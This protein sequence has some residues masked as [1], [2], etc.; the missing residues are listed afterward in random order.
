MLNN[1]V[2]NNLVLVK[3]TNINFE[4]GFC[5]ITGQSGSGKSVI[6][7]AI[8]LVLGGRF[9]K[10]F[11]REG[12]NQGFI[13]AEFD[14]SKNA[15][16]KDLL[17]QKA[18][19]NSENPDIL[20][21]RRA[22]FDNNTTKAFI[23]DIAVT[24]TLLDEIGSQIAQIQSQHQQRSLLEV[25]NQKII[26]DQYVDD[27]ELLK[28]VAEK[29]ENWQ[30]LTN[31]LVQIKEKEEQIL[32]EKNYLEYVIKELKDANI[33][34]NEEEELLEKKNLLKNK[35][36]IIKLIGEAKFDIATTDS[37]M[38]N[39][40]NL[41]INNKELFTQVEN[42]DQAI[43]LSDEITLK[44][45]QISDI[46]ADEFNNVDNVDFDLNEIDDRL[47]LIRNLSRKFNIQP[48]QFAEIL[49]SWEE[50]LAQID[51]DFKNADQLV[52]QIEKIFNEY[53][54]E[55]EKLSQIRQEMA[56]K[57]RAKCNEELEFLAM[58]DTEF[59]IDIDRLE[60]KNYS[61]SGIDKVL[62]LA[63]INKAKTPSEINKIA[64]GGELSRFM[65]ALKN[66]VNEK[67]S[68]SVI[69]FDEIDAGVSGIIA[70]KIGQRLRHLA[71]NNQIIAITHNIQVAAR[72]N[73]HI[74]VEKHE[75]DGQI[76]SNATILQKE[77]RKK[78]LE[79]MIVIE[80]QD[81]DLFCLSFKS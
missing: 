36:S 29:F 13:L 64:S 41:L 25:K 1:L 80:D 77:Q 12:E 30:N 42:I 24:V 51:D 31:Q 62:F 15:K 28:N 47:F 26:L 66:A 61:A 52:E 39:L 17:Q 8:F 40:Q 56:L 46:L 53:L 35:E 50:K 16:I 81:N 49:T 2:I 44:L 45:Q 14:I 7:N 9:N 74:L 23:N 70:D 59:V 18:L 63:K 76:I 21:I 75:I 69:I 43:D 5:I 3:N 4:D 65:L 72:A 11:L 78:A 55:A 19:I 20:I 10:K 71:Q 37:K 68:S 60:E 22:F 73:C 38:S 32:R 67:K 48:S 6:L 27:K 54:V 57:L 33:G 34:E 79:E 58:Q